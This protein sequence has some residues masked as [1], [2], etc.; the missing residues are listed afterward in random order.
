MMKREDLFEA[1]GALD[2]SLLE[3]TAAPVPKF[4]GLRRI[5]PV[6]IAACLVIGAG[7]LLIGNLPKRPD[8]STPLTQAE[9]IEQGI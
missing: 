7:A 5:L 1:I 2:A 6:G 3:E 4:A 9:K 8:T